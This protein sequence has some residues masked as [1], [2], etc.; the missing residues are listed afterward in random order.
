MYHP[1]IISIN[2]NEG[3][4]P[5]AMI[6]YCVFTVDS[7]KTITGARVVKQVVLINGLPFEIK[8]IYGMAEESDSVEG[9]QH[10][11]VKDDDGEK[12]CLICLSEAK[13]TLIMP[14][15]HFCICSDC[16]KG[17][18]KAKHTCPVCRGNIGSLIPMKK[19]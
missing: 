16:G 18:I 5:Y 11:D 3:S 13:D 19:H 6:S 4:S 1:L 10:I 9:K 7:Q 12:E 2:Y 17:L 14:C 8:S 15:G